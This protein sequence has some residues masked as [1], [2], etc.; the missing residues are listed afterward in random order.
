MRL[1]VALLIAALA[2]ATGC[3]G[4]GTSD[5]RSAKKNISADSQG[6]AKSML[7]R[8]SDFP[9]GWRASAPKPEDVG[10]ERKFRKCLGVDFS[11]LTLTGD[12][13]SRDF[14][15]GDSTEASSDAQITGSSAQAREG[16]RELATALSSNA[17][18]DCVTKLIPHSSVYKIGEVDAG[19]L[20]VTSPPGVEKARAWQIVVPVEVTSGASKGLTATAYLDIVAL[21]KGDAVTTVQTSDVLTAFD[22]TL[23]DELVRKVAGRMG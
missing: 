3:G 13:T 19:E 16:F 7:L 1:A 2:A 10:G 8:L 11:N 4:G 18:K 17:V 12:A 21:L 23:R 6:R 14:A 5:T 9:E 15:M 20:R 22:P